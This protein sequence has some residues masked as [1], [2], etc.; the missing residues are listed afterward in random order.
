[1]APLPPNSTGRL[2]TKYLANTRQ[3][4]VQ[5][6]YE[7]AGAPGA[8]VLE[9]LDEWFTDHNPIMPEDWVFIDWWY[10][11][12]GSDISVPL[13]NAPTP[14]DGAGTPVFGQAPS[15]IDYVGRSPGGKRV[16]LGLIGT[17]IDYSSGA[18]GNQ[19]YRLTR[20]EST[21]VNAALNTLAAAP[22]VAIDGGEPRW[23]AYADG[24][25]NAYWQRKLRS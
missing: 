20:A 1:M 16:R 24:G 19:N 18:I 23:K 9:S 17:V 13:D 11:P 12:D 6:R 15:F 2:I 21:V 25:Y 5:V 3:H 10:I 14:F 7:G 22:F 8:D 4:T